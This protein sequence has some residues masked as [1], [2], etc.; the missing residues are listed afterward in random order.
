MRLAP[1]HHDPDDQH[2]ADQ[3]HRQHGEAGDGRQLP[4]VRRLVHVFTCRLHRDEVS[5]APLTFGMEG[6]G[7][8]A[9]RCCSRASWGTSCT[10]RRARRRPG[11]S[12]RTPSCC[13]DLRTQNHQVERVRNVEAG[14]KQRS[15]SPKAKLKTKAAGFQLK[16]ART[17]P[18]LRLPPPSPPS[19]N[20]ELG[21]SS[22]PDC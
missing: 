7:W 10:T 17:A 3:H 6:E 14:E 5:A 20:T 13:T 4:H 19:H 9:Y 1:V 18:T 8:G 15:V 11:P 22:R 12:S 2:G 16:S 21:N